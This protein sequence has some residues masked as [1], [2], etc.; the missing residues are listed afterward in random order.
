MQEEKMKRLIN[1]ASFQLMEL[2]SNGLN[3]PG[4]EI[5]RLK[6]LTTKSIDNKRFKQNKI[7]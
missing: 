6:N 3:T 1:F 7:I 2:K 4:M 5:N